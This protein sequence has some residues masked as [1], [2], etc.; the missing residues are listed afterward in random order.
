MKVR[1]YTYFF[2]KTIVINCSFVRK[3]TQ[4]WTRRR[5]NNGYDMKSTLRL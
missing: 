4:E 3:R 5:I 2:D 1:M